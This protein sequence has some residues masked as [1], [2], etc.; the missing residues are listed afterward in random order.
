MLAD[1]LGRPLRFKL[2]PGQQHDLVQ[3]PAM[4]EGFKADALLADTAYDSRAFREAVTA[5][6]AEPVIP[7]NPTRKHPF[8]YDK[9]KYKLRNRIERCFNKLK[10]FRRVATRFDKLARN[11][12][13]KRRPGFRS[14][15]DARL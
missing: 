7:S 12:L 15:L 13:V 2:A 1:A 4:I 6:G 3:A 14:L 11:F 10:H 5:I 9:S 8:G